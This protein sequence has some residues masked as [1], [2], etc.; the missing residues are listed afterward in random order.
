MEIF[1]HHFSLLFG[2]H[3]VLAFHLPCLAGK[4]L[5]AVSAWRKGEANQFEE[6]NGEHAKSKDDASGTYCRSFVPKIDDV[7]SYGNCQTSDHQLKLR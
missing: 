4:S 2:F 1:L 7:H 5:P 6:E 3:A